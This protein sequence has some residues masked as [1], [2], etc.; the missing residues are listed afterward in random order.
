ML[1]FAL[2][3]GLRRGRTS[4]QMPVHQSL[5]IHMLTGAVLIGAC[6]LLQGSILSPLSREFAIG[7]V[8]L[9]LIATFLTY[10]IYYTMLRVYPVAMS[11]AVGF[12]A[13]GAE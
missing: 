12:Q 4:L 7:M 13:T 2:A 5:C 6:A 8:C 1:A 11:T 10:A 9:V 3:S